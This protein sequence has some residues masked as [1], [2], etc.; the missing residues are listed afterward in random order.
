[1]ALLLEALAME[2]LAAP[3][4]E[5]AVTLWELDATG[6]SALKVARH[7]VSSL[8]DSS[9]AP[10]IAKAIASGTLSNLTHEC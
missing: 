8:T 3:E 2:L 7:L 10:E 9:D 1:L 6:Q 5:V 4:H